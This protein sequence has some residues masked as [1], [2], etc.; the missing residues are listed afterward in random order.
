MT[1]KKAVSLLLAVS[2]FLIP[3]VV[4]IPGLSFAAGIALSILLMAALL[5]MTEPIP[6]YATSVLV[7]LLGVLLL[8]KDG[9]IFPAQHYDGLTLTSAADYF[10]TLANSIIILFLGGLLLADAAVKFEMDK[11]L[12]RWILKPFGS[13]PKNILLGLLLVTGSISAFMSNTATTAM[14][15]AIVLPVISRFPKEDK[16]RIAAVLAIPFGANIGGIATPVGTPPNAVALAALAK[17]GVVIPFGSWVLMASPVALLGLGFVWIV[18]RR[19]Y[20]SSESMIEVQVGGTFQKSSG[21]VAFYIV[22]GA[23]AVLWMTESLHGIS[24]GII[25][26]FAVVGLTVTGVVN[27]HDIRKLPWEVLWLVAGGIALDVAMRSTGLAQ[28]MV[29]SVA[30]ST[31][32]QV[33]VL[34]AFILIPLLLAQFLS[35]TVCATLLMPLAIQVGTNLSQTRPEFAPLAAVSLAIGVSFAMVLPI[36]TPPNAIATATGMVNTREMSKAGAVIGIVGFLITLLCSL[37]Y[38]PLFLS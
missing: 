16:F 10:N 33:G 12:T 6:I 3:L 38:W 35:H 26:F 20:P 30:W 37:F 23:T 2:A 24:S 8:S 5:W 19:W 18:L 29:S 9:L 22:G 21:A 36:S 14:M 28:W 4:P 7:I 32:G 25:S 13:K 34:A 11:N 17:T 27:E 1:R 31:F 15:M